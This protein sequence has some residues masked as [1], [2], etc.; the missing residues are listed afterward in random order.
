MPVVWHLFY[1]M[2]NKISVQLLID[3]VTNKQYTVQP[4]QV[5]PISC[6]DCINVY[7]AVTFDNDSW[8]S[9]IKGEEPLTEQELLSRGRHTATLGY[10]GG[11]TTLNLKTMSLKHTNMPIID[12]ISKFKTCRGTLINNSFPTLFEKTKTSDTSMFNVDTAKEI[13]VS[14]SCIPF[15]FDIKQAAAWANK[16]KKF[17]ANY[18]K[19]IKNL[20][21]GIPGVSCDN[22]VSVDS[23]T[24]VL[25]DT[26]YTKGNITS[27]LNY[28]KYYLPQLEF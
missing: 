27:V 24:R 7:S 5:V 8:Y 6:I 21:I 4:G 15:I 3:L 16:D 28:G 19:H 10:G 2:K 17:I 1:F 18:I 23:T 25:Y 26:P 12:Y 14:K 9:T 20:L 22:S 11:K 13:N